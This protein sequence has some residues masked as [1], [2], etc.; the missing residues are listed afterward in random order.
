MYR[1]DKISDLKK[2]NS[3][4]LLISRTDVRT[5]KL[6]KEIEIILRYNP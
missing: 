6:F 4:L 5:N 2:N 3:I 1:I